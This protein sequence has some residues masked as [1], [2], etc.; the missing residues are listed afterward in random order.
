M[1]R[2]AAFIA[3]AFCACSAT[4]A[5]DAD[6]ITALPGWDHELPSKQYSGFLSAEETPTPGHERK[7][8]YV[9]VEAENSPETAPV[10]L[11]TNGGPGCSSLDGLVYEHGPFRI[12]ATDNTKLVRFDHTWAKLANML[13]LEAPVGVGF[14]YSDDASDYKKC[15]DDTVEMARMHSVMSSESPSVYSTR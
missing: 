9:F 6:E 3:V 12:N 4:A 7:L 15:T 14:S 13:Y 2:F 8:H 5:V 10:V 1:R 11:W